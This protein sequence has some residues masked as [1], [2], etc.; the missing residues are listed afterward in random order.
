MTEFK[1]HLTFK[2][3]TNLVKIPVNLILNA[4][5]PRLLG[6]VNYGNFDFLYDSA[7]KVIGFFDTGSSIAFYTRLSQNHD[8]RLLIKFY[9]WVVVLLISTYFLFVFGAG[10][11]GYTDRVWPNQSF[12]FI[13]LS[14]VLGVLSFLSSTVILIIDASN[15]TVRSEKVRMAQLVISLVIYG[16]IFLVFKKIDL[17]YFFYIQSFLVIFLIGGCWWVLESSR[18]SI[19]STEK[20]TKPLI[21]EFGAYFWKFSNPLLVYSIV[22]LLVGIGGRW[23]LQQYGGS[24]QQAYFG[25]ASKVGS[26]VLLFTTAL[27]PLLM[28]EYSKLFGKNDML[29]L[30]RLYVLSF[31]GLYIISMYISVLVFFNADFI[32]VFLGGAEFKKSTLV[33]SIMAFYPVH[34]S[35]GQINGSLF[36]STQRNKEYR[37]V[38][39]FFMPLG[40]LLSF[41]LIAPFGLFGLNLGA[42]GLAIQMVLIQI[43]TVNANNYL[44]CRFFKISFIN[45]VVY[46]IAIP[47]IFLLIGF[48]CNIMINMITQAAFLKLLLFG[49]LLTIF[50]VCLIYLFPSIIGFEK[51]EQIQDLLK[52][53]KIKTTL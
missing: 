37:N 45:L 50:A 3:L 51:R 13:L 46:Q 39:L 34:Q 7:T 41:F 18:L 8:D 40:L 12:Y 43:L 35:L 36:Y 49:T 42:K 29:G 10:I 20:L 2:I 48:L 27:M 33:L 38:G 22:S 47:A 9:W 15:L 16:F 6:P 25:L 31:K 30:S 28:R 24:I 1:K 19:F 26:F 52:F 44:N 21:K 32:S 23:I 53:G 17:S 4:L 5:F 11:F 14:A